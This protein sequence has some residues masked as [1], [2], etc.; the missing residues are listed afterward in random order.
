MTEGIVKRHTLPRVAFR[1]D[2]HGN[3]RHK[4]ISGDGCSHAGNRG[5]HHT[6]SEIVSCDWPGGC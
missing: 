6:V 5:Q 4:G 2:S 3:Q 1:F